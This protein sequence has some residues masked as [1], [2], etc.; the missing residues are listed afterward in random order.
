M[1]VVDVPLSKPIITEIKSHYR[2]GEILRGNCSSQYSRPAANLT[3]LMNDLPV[4]VVGTFKRFFF[5][6]IEN[7][8][9]FLLLFRFSI[10]L[11]LFYSESS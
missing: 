9:D 4:S 7:K 8:L 6:T 5:K 2:I 1:E 10:F 11:F 3:W